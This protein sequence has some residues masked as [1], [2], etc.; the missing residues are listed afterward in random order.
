MEYETNHD[1]NT[2]D[3]LKKLYSLVEHVWQKSTDDFGDDMET[4]DNHS[5]SFIAAYRNIGKAINRVSILT[6]TCHVDGL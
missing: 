6:G 3:I 5:Q 1:R 4:S 2:H